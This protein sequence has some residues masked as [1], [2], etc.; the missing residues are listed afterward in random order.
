MIDD[1]FLQR[2][3]AH[4]IASRTQ[5]YFVSAINGVLR[6]STK[7][8]ANKPS[9]ELMQ[10]TFNRTMNFIPGIESGMID[11]IRNTVDMRSL[12]IYQKKKRDV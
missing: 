6:K 2:N 4:H 10:G 11:N 1:H 12:A 7:S 3:I 8:D 9:F 5:T